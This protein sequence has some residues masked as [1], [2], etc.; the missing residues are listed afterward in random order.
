MCESI[1]SNQILVL[2]LVQS[3]KCLLHL[4]LKSISTCSEFNLLLFSLHRFP[5]PENICSD[6]TLVG[7]ELQNCFAIFPRK[8]YLLSL[9]CQY[10]NGSPCL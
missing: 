4:I 3:I 6:G 5:T 7:G 1:Q 9:S 2:M 10:F 8:G